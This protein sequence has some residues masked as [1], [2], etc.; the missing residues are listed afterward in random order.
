MRNVP[1]QANT[2]M[3]VV[4]DEDDSAAVR[5]VEAEDYGSHWQTHRQV[6]NS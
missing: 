3:T 6:V 4:C 1:A 2:K 5:N